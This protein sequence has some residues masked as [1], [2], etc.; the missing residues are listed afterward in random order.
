MKFRV[1]AL[2]PDLARPHA[3]QVYVF[4]LLA[5]IDREQ[6][7]RHLLDRHVHALGGVAAQRMRL[8]PRLVAVVQLFLDLAEGA[9][10]VQFPALDAALAGDSEAELGA[11]RA[12][13]RRPNPFVEEFFKQR[14]HLNS[15][16]P[17]AAAAPSNGRS[18][19][20]RSTLRPG[21]TSGR[22]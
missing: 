13:H 18:P 20:R 5:D 21:S 16:T 2:V 19:I 6:L 7:C 3:L 14:M 15:S 11:R 12:G 22:R 1:L 8:F 17:R 10:E 9:G 4:L